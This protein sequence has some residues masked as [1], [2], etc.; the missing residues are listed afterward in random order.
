MVCLANSSASEAVSAGSGP[1][2]LTDMVLESVAGFALTILRSAPA[3][4]GEPM[5]VLTSSAT[6]REVR[7]S[8]VVTRSLCTSSDGKMAVPNKA[9]SIVCCCLTSNELARYWGVVVKETIRLA[10]KARSTTIT[11]IHF[12]RHRTVPSDRECWLSIFTPW[13]QAAAA[14]WLHPITVKP[15]GVR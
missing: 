13:S 1:V 4:R 8:A 7:V 14:R 11:T 9:T 2:T 6:R 12:L 15:T 3:D 5:D 10:P